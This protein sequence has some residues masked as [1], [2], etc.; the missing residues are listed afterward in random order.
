MN[1]PNNLISKFVKIT[2]TEIP[3]VKE[4]TVYGTAKIVNDTQYVKIDGSE[5]LT[6]VAT[7][8]T[9]A[10]GERVTVMVKNHT[11][12]ITG[13]I[14]SPS[15]RGKDLELTAKSLK[16][17]IDGALESAGDAEKSASDAM[18][19]AG[20]AKKSA[21]DAM[22]AAESA[23]NEASNAKRYATDYL[24]L[25]S[26][27]LELGNAALNTNLL[28]TSN[29]IDFRNG[30][31]VLASYQS[32]YIYLGKANRKATI[33]LADGVGRLYNED[34]TDFDYS[35]LVIE[36]DHS[37][38]LNAMCA[39]YGNT[40]YDNGT[41]WGDA[42]IELSS[43]VPW[44]PNNP[45]YIGGDIILSSSEGEYYGG[46]TISSSIRLNKGVSIET[47]NIENGSSAKISIN[48]L[49]SVNITGGPIE[50]TDANSLISCV[51]YYVTGDYITVRW[52]GAGFITNSGSDI[53]FSIP[54]DGSVLSSRSPSIS[55]ST[56][57]KIRQDNKYLYGSGSSTHVHP[58]SYTATL[59]GC[60]IRVIAKM[61]NTT[62]VTN[63]SPC[64]VEAS[65]NISF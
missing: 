45:S 56:G 53:Y 23:A 20:D 7:T 31:T 6:P 3:S 51:P 65:V 11:A 38:S 29:S 27:G 16:I 10:D 37:I 50:L 34:D 12:T 60:W 2:E 43:H 17:E 35:R 33:D 62:N 24:N 48:N 52:T 59:D 14:S 22:T 21:S 13:N 25:S 61:S 42:H 63:N 64:G 30:S 18:T 1:L 44:D 41:K 19:A 9:V 32:D 39:I 57:L 55:S 15:A 40:Y 47:N 5:V 58:S 36:A 28:L 46:N 4:T 26:A 8:S 54:L 49:G